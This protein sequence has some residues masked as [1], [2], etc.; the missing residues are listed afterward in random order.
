MSKWAIDNIDAINPDTGLG[1]TVGY[2]EAA[3][4]EEAM[5]RAGEQG[6]FGTGFYGA[7][8]VGEEDTDA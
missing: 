5:R 4:Q 1:V 2:V 3:T 7:R 6:L 8:P